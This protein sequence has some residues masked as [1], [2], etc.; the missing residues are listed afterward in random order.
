[1]S[2]FRVLVDAQ[3]WFVGSTDI[4]NTFHQM[5]ILRWLQAFYALPA[6]LASED[7]FFFFWENDKPKDLLPIP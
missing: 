1:M 5:R 2:N 6:V 3:N 4:K 7:G